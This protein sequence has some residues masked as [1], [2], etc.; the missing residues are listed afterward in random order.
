MAWSYSSP[1]HLPLTTIWCLY[2]IVFFRCQLGSYRSSK[3]GK[4]S[5]VMSFHRKISIHLVQLSGKNGKW[6]VQWFCI[7]CI[8]FHLTAV[9]TGSGATFTA[10]NYTP[11]DTPMKCRCLALIWVPFRTFIL[12]YCSNTSLE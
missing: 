8:F 11:A 2:L 6:L 12:L 10:G 9:W 1:Q 7:L 3:F 4:M 5:K